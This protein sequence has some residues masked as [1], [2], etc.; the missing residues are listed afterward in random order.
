MAKKRIFVTIQI[1]G[2]DLECGVL[3][4]SVR[5]NRESLTFSYAPSYLEHSKAFALSPDMPLGPGTFHSLGVSQIRAFSDCM[6][7]RW[8]QNLMRRQ[9]ARLAKEQNRT[10]RTLFELN[11]LCGVND[12]QR[13][14]AIRLWD[15]DGNV[16]SAPNKGVPKE[17]E[18]PALLDAADLAASDLSADVRDLFAAG[19]SLGGARPKASISAADGSLFIAKFPRK[20]ESTLDDICAWEKVALDIFAA[21]GLCVPSSKLLR[22]SGRAVL[23]LKRFD[24]K[25]DKLDSK[26]N[27]L[28]RKNDSLDCK[29]DKPN[30][31]NDKLDHKNDKRIAYLSGLSAISG[32]DGKEG[33]SYL[34][35]LDFLV[36]KGANTTADKQQ[37]WL[38]ALLSAAIG[39]TDNH[40]RNFGFLRAE[41]GWQL[42]PFFDINPTRLEAGNNFSVN[43]ADAA[44]PHTIDSVMENAAFFDIDQNAAGKLAEKALLAISNWRKIASS[45][46]IKESSIAAMQS[47]MELAIRTLKHYVD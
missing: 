47:R 37:L 7:D 1:D 19:S 36:Q 10:P 21:C 6:P 29:N 24:R 26:N 3:D 16:L 17:M 40:M 5:N 15:A 43:I 44:V 2:K 33:Y 12:E 35:L 30:C 46:A 32:N 27:K 8:G 34:D 13:Q 25:N 9:E 18:L 23:L 22:F 42:C 11:L 28:D 4:Q 39:N 45:Y 41:K 31:K 38:H 20:D 14:G